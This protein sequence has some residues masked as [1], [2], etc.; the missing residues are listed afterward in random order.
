[1]KVCF[2]FPAII[3][4][5]LFSCSS[6]APE[7][8]VKKVKEEAP[9]EVVSRFRFENSQDSAVANG[10]SIQRY[11]NG[12]IKMQGMMK[13]GK[14]EGLWKSWYEDGKPWSE[15]TFSSGVR[16]GKTTTWYDNGNKRYQGA[17]TNDIES[18][19]WI[20]W[21]EKGKEVST[22]DYSIK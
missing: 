21:D 2:I 8:Q 3:S 6:E 5:T 13:E 15:T 16:N 12:G 1:M 22:K 9:V 14:R 20:Y 18:G 10:E 4:I 7:E 17:Y 19:K 11:K